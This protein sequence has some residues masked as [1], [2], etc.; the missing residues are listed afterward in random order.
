MLTLRDSLTFIAVYCFIACVLLA[1]LTEFIVQAF[2]AEGDAA[3][4]IRVF[5]YGLSIATV[6]NGMTFATNALFNNLRVA[7]WATGFNFAK[8]TLFTMPFVS[9]GAAWGGPAG[10]YWGLLMGSALIGIAGVGVAYW[11]I[12]GLK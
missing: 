8:A 9:I 1:L 3:L 4:L 10:I 5:C 2:N 7:T 11:K 6:F 12:K